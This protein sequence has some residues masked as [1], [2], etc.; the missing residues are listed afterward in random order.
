LEDLGDNPFA[1]LEQ[2]QK[3]VLGFD[4]LMLMLL[5]NGLR[6][7][8]SLLGLYGI[9]VKSHLTSFPESELKFL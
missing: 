3:K 6:F 5:R 9:F 8:Q 1:L 7:L 2:R 4:L